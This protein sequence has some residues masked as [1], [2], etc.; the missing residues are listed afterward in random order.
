LAIEAAAMPFTLF[1][2]AF[3]WLLFFHDPIG[4]SPKSELPN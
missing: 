4:Q 2:L 3:A 1:T